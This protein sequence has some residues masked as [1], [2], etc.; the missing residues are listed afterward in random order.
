MER[1]DYR[2]GDRVLA[3]FGANPSG[4]GWNGWLNTERAVPRAVLRNRDLRTTI[5]ESARAALAE[6][7]EKS[8]FGLRT[9]G[10]TEADPN[11]KDVAGS[12]DVGVRFTP[13]TTHNGVRVGTR[14]RL[15]DVSR[16][17]PD[18]LKVRTHALATRILFDK[19]KRAIGVEYLAGERLYRADPNPSAQAGE[20]R[21]V[22]ASREVILAG[23]AFNTPQLLM[24]SGVGDPDELAQHKIPVVVD[25]PGVGRNLQDRYEVSAVYRMAFDAWSVLEGATYSAGDPY[26]RDWD[27]NRNGPYTT[28]GAMLAVV[29]RSSLDRPV[30]DLFCYGIIEP[31]TGYYPGYT[32]AFAGNPN[33]LTWVV[34]KGHTNNTAGR[35]TLSTGDPRD[36]PR[37]TFKYFEEGN[38]A[39][40]DDLRSVVDGLQFVRRLSEGLRREG[41]V[42]REES[43]GEHIKSPEDLQQF[44]RDTAW[45]HHAS[46]TCR[47]GARELGGVLTPTLKVHGTTG[48]RIVDASVFPKIPG[49]FI[50]SAVY[51]VG[52]KAAEMILAERS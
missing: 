42:A 3:K 43:P 19:A 49:L 27:V 9:I 7:A 52:E 26:Y 34:L 40:G 51:M 31:F 22:M 6:A 15:L 20:V 10:N 32:S 36:R 41:L 21:Q 1:C 30:P 23:G 11:D 45:G 37:I 24:L 14:E 17:F 47:I 12:E 38:D 4:H 48:L 25:L 50:A 8:H 29:L 33:C 16:R 39:A 28:N 18:L 2:P 13:L 44:V 5:I 35:V 46:C